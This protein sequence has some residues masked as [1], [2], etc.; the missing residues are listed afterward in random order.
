MDT[1]LLS[2]AHTILYSLKLEQLSDTRYIQL[3]GNPDRFGYSQGFLAVRD[4]VGVWD[5]AE[6]GDR[7]SFND[8]RHVASPTSAH[9]ILASI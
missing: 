9:S 3:K 1:R 2:F 7:P 4:E 5:E 6:V 8:K